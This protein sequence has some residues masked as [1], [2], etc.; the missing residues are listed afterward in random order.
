[1]GSLSRF[2]QQTNYPG[3]YWICSALTL[4][5][6]WG[7]S[8]LFLG[9][10]PSTHPLAASSCSWSIWI[11]VR[12]CWAIATLK[13]HKHNGTLARTTLCIVGSSSF[14]SFLLPPSPLSPFYSLNSLFPSTSV[15]SLLPLPLRACLRP[16]QLC[17]VAPGLRIGLQAPTTNKILNGRPRLSGEIMRQT[18]PEIPSVE[19]TASEYQQE[20]GVSEQLEKS[21][22]Q[23]LRG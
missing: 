18:G 20:S 11:L 2:L 19:Q 4:R 21:K 15:A 13:L 9:T 12:L 6:S 3:I 7:R 22:G 17:S 16:S 23:I 8:N 5:S 10:P 1:M 14:L